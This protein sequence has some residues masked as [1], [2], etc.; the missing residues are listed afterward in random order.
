[1]NNLLLSTKIGSNLPYT[2]TLDQEKMLESL[3][4]FLFS[5]EENSIFLLKGYA[6]TGKS[7]LI[8]AVVQTIIQLSQNVVLLA[9]TGRAARIFSQYSGAPAQTIHRKIYRQSKAYGESYES[10]L[11]INPHKNTIFFVDEASMISTRG[12]E[13]R[14]ASILEELIEYVYSAENCR[15][16]L[17]GDTAQL[18]PVGESDSPALVSSYIG[19]FGL[20]VSEYTLTQVVRQAEESGIL[21]NATLLRKYMQQEDLSTLPK[22][23][24]KG[25]KDIKA[26][27]G[28]DLPDNLNSSYNR[29][30][31]EETIIITRS[32]KRA[33]LFN[34]GIRA[35]VLYMEEELSTGD[36]L[37]ISKNNYFV[38]TEYRDI[39]FIANG[40]I[41]QVTRVR[42]REELYGFH[43]AEVSIHL[44]D[45]DIDIDI[46]IIT[47]SLHSESATLTNEQQNTLFNNVAEEYL[48]IGNQ[49]AIMRK[50]KQ[51]PFFNALQVKYAY[52]LTCHKAQGGQ[53]KEVY[54][55]L[56]N[57]NPQ[58]IG[59]DFYRWLYTAITRSTERV[60]LVNM[61]EEMILM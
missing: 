36:L 21:W 18:P 5:K 32:N 49:N 15:L 57:I 9:P 17:I 41:A 56:A 19:G 2:P 20:E 47:E 45:R 44:F 28:E 10:Q 14:G 12:N 25:F 30:G 39:D 22:L 37:L 26:I 31:S 23:D 58:H 52:C 7:S 6:G 60:Y 34:N 13:S 59:L 50:I 24:L 3:I 40:E 55:D 11:N 33:K 46:K 61:P 8:G 54:I 51:D 42:R 29:S 38:A 16:I 4:S 43:F 48:H 53:W 27:G 35:Q 1:M